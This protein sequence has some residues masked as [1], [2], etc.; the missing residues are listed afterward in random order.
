MMDILFF[1]LYVSFRLTQYLEQY[2]KPLLLFAR[3][4]LDFLFL[5][6]LF[7]KSQDNRSRATF[8]MPRL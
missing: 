1:N 8:H 4:P 7:S 3:N 2:L 5:I 6:E